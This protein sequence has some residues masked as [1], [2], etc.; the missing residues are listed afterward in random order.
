MPE[1]R[2][3]A[4]ALGVQLPGV[5]DAEHASSLLELARLGKT[6]GV[7]VVAQVS[8]KRPRLDTGSVVGEG[9]LRELAAL[10]GG[11]GV[12]PTGPPR[13]RSKPEAEAAEETEPDSPEAAAEPGPARASVVL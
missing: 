12:V 4:V 13:R 8:Q 10:T 3:S 11:S 5:S 7:E 2:K 1:E 9:K 6:L